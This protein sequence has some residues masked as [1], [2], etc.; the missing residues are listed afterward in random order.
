MK[1]RAN[2]RN[3]L[4]FNF[5]L[6][7][8]LPILVI[9]GIALQIL[10]TGMER[11]LTDKNF[12]LA[13]TLAG[14]VDRFLEEPMNFLKHTQEVLENQDLTQPERI[15]T[16]L[17]AIIKI[18]RFFETLMI[19]D[20]DGLIRYLAPPKDDFI[21]FDMSAH[22]FFRMTN[23]LR[24][25]YWSPTFI[26]MRTGQPTLT[27]SLPMKQGMLVGDVN[28][29]LLNAITDKIKIGSQGYAVI[30]DQDGTAIAHPNKVYVSER[31]NLRNIDLSNHGF[32]G[33][34]GNFRYLFMGEETLSSIV[35]VSKT[36]WIVAVIQPV[37]HAFAHV[38]RIRN[39]I[40]T[41]AVAAIALAIML[42]LSSLKKTLKPLL[43]LTEDSK[44]I[45]AGDYSLN[46]RSAGY[47]EIDNLQ[48]NFKAMID[49]V[50]AREEALR[51]AHAELEHRVEERTAQLKQAKEAAEVA[52]QA[53]SDFLSN[54]SHELRTPLNG[55]LGY[56]H[57]LKQ[58]SNLT[59]TQKSQL[60]I[61][62]SSGK[63]LL[64]MINEIL[65]L[66]KIEAQK[67]EVESVEFN[68]Q[69]V[70]HHVYNLTKVHAEAKNLSVAYEERSP[71]P[72]VVRGDER[73]LTQILLNLSGNA[74]KYTE[75]G[76]V[77]LRVSRFAADDL[78]GDE[79]LRVE[80]ED[81][82]VG[83]LQDQL[84]AIFE[85]FTRVGETLKTTEGAGLGLAITHKLVE[86]LHGT[87]SVVSALGKGSTFRV[88]LPLPEVE[89]RE[90]AAQR[91]QL[92]IIGYQ[93]ERK[94]IL[95]A[96]D[97]PTNLGMLVSLLESLGFVLATARNGQEVVRHALTIPPDLI[98]LD[99]LMPDMD[100]LEAAR[101][102]RK[103]PELQ[104]T[105]I[106]GVSAT[107]SER[108]NAHA[109]VSACDDFLSKP[110]NLDLLLDKIQAHLRLTWDVAQG[111]PETDVSVSGG[112]AQI[113]PVT[114]LA[115]LRQ[116]LECGNFRKIEK[117][118]CDLECADPAYAQFCQ[119]IR[120]YAERYDSH[121]IL[122]YLQSITEVA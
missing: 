62:Q 6:V 117:F 87:L 15:N 37:E 121:G 38:R 66:G 109:F 22:V 110:I 80:I 100:G 78:P 20:H 42:A 74:V 84:E 101:E 10:S 68:L 63:H 61:I 102:L 47:R 3:A 60:D 116:H 83:I 122:R 34:E 112:T 113:P 94:R 4:T 35:I 8:T 50:K 85:P 71:L 57:I 103:H 28:L 118:L 91:A 16:Q 55:I 90:V 59:S 45:A 95:A 40:W 73:K 51:K 36:H 119:N 81:T 86:L 92:R 96:D 13:K 18:Y 21:G 52:N 93:G 56:A 76:Q 11:E 48:N 75:R 115:G 44:R 64:T 19:L 67:V 89:N 82:G 53:K 99:Y 14:E 46:L 97:N 79:H 25:P 29:S 7:A 88:E 5:V 58:Q 98:L 106:I 23:E 105:P 27:L 17:A 77:T 32:K 107:V 120:Q 1:S 33:E 108:A 54:M 65:D 49:A 70:L 104:Q 69:T 111:I 72:F 2:L 30:A 39:I 26:S 9:G 24:E 12:L 41:G 43:Q 31:V 114:M